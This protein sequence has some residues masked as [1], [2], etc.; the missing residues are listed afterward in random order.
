MRTYTNEDGVF[1]H[2][3]D[4][5]EVLDRMKG[6]FKEPA[7]NSMI[8]SIVAALEVLERRALRHAVRY[9]QSSLFERLTRFM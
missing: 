1:V 4:L 6:T 8:V 2:V 3:G 5:A 7:A 9:Q